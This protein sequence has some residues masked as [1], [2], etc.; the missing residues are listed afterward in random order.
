VA[1]PGVGATSRAQFFETPR[2]PPPTLFRPQPFSAVKSPTEPVDL[3]SGVFLRCPRGSKTT[4][5]EGKARPQA[6]LGLAVHLFHQIDFPAGGPQNSSVGVL[7][8]PSPPNVPPVS[9][10]AGP[11]PCGFH[12]HRDAEDVG[13]LP[14]GVSPRTSSPFSPRA[15]PPAVRLHA[16]AFCLF[17]RLILPSTTSFPFFPHPAESFFEAESILPGSA[18]RFWWLLLPPPSH[19]FFRASRL[20]PPALSPRFGPPSPVDPT[21]P[22]RPYAPPTLSLARG[23]PNN[24]P[25]F[26]NNL[27]SQ[28]ARPPAPSPLIGV[29]DLRVRC[30]RSVFHGLFANSP[31]VPWGLFAF[32]GLA[33]GRRTYEPSFHPAFRAD[34]RCLG[35]LTQATVGGSFRRADSEADL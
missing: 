32:F 20:L 7:W 10:T 22:P 14:L 9:P 27:S 1:P 2:S 30:S 6:Y 24:S 26:A 15:T 5:T 35:N 12:Y 17:S 34:P 3:S 16:G 33:L 11:S 4:S 18:P 29:P 28:L 25:I 8:P 13:P 21:L 19:R 23:R 31:H